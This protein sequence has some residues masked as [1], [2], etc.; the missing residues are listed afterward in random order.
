MFSSVRTL[1]GLLFVL[2]CAQLG[3]P[4]IGT[5]Q[6][7][8]VNGL[9]TGCSGPSGY[10]WAGTSCV[11]TQACNCTGADCNGLYEKKDVCE[12]AHAHCL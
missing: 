8:E 1:L 11:Y 12:A 6:P 9:K 2:G 3:C 5:C 7:Q 4:R 10:M